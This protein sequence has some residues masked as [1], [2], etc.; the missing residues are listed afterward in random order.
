MAQHRVPPT[1]DNFSVWFYYAMG[2]SLTLKKTI[3]ILIANKRKFDS[4]VN[5]DLYVTYVKPQHDLEHER[6]I[7]R[8]DARRDRQRPGFSG[9]R[10][11][12]QSLA[13]GEPRRSQIGVSDHGRSA[14]DHRKAGER[15]VERD[16][17][18]LGARGEFPQHHERSR[19]DQGL[20][21]ARRAALQH[22]PA[23]RA[24]QPPF[25]RGIPARPPRSRRWKRER[26]SAS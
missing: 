1:P 18:F 22:R 7:P 4:V 9:D 8:A 17:A 26:R 16:V 24:R 23:H 2:G 10:H 14:A 20:A 19:S 12:R 6:G 11:F 21:E 25:A 13:D 5:R 15:A 3:D